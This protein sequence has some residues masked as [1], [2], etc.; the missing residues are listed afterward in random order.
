MS[1]IESTTS[2]TDWTA[3][4]VALSAIIGLI[5]TIILHLDSARKDRNIRFNELLENFSHE[6]S[7]IRLREL[8]I[9]TVE[10]AIRYQKDHIHTVNRLAYLR[11]LNKINDDMINFFDVSFIH[12]NT[13]IHWEDKI[14]PDKTLHEEIRWK[15]AKWWI[16]K[17]N[18]GLEDFRALPPKLFEMYKKIEDGYVVVLN[19]GKCD[20]VKRKIIDQSKSDSQ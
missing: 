20:F 19:A 3:I 12:A 10:S 16:K 6:L 1:G 18:M 11:K 17:K 2:N 15:Y 8:S 7:A 9:D 4:I 14:L 13:L 5:I